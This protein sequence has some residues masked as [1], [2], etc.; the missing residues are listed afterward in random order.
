MSKNP[1]VVEGGFNSGRGGMHMR[2]DIAGG[3][4]VA[5]PSSMT[6]QSVDI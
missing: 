4:G 5:H 3:P 2:L 6:Q 1:S